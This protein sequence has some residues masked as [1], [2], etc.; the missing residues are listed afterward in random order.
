MNAGAG[1]DAQQCGAEQ[2]PGENQSAHHQTDDNQSI[3]PGAA[4]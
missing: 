3:D 4:S 2:Q 1:D